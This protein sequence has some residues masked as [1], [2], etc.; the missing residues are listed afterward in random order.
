M[1][2]G[3]GIDT[4]VPLVMRNTSRKCRRP[5][6]DWGIIRDELGSPREISICFN[7]ARIRRGEIPPVQKPIWREFRGLREGNWKSIGIKYA[8]AYPRQQPRYLEKSRSRY[9][10]LDSSVDRF[11]N[12]MKT[13]RRLVFAVLRALTFCVGALRTR[14][15]GQKA[16]W[17]RGSSFQGMA[18]LYRRALPA[19]FLAAHSGASNRGILG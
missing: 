1:S 11:S 10:N 14:L 6:L 13:T 19:G 16:A 18:L 7:L 9:L 15:H 12:G 4:V 17:L 2:A 8:L 5:P 3:L